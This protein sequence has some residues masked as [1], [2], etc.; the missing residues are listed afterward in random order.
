MVR[1][2]D[3]LVAR[4]A[5]AGI[6]LALACA[7]SSVPA[8]AQGPDPAPTQSGP[9]PDPAPGAQPAPTAAPTAPPVT[10]TPAPVVTQAPA[11]V[12]PAPTATA[13]EPVAT[14]RPAA[15]KHPRPRAHRRPHKVARRH[16][17][18]QPAGPAPQIRRIL[19]ESSRTPG[20]LPKRLFR[21]VA[22]APREQPQPQSQSRDRLL[23]GSALA[24]LAVAASTL[25][26][27]AQANRIRRELRPS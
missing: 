13:P 27:L 6:V 9:Q 14:P 21:P 17:E 22:R 10:Q 2:R 19:A 3:G 8:L 4:T 26:L 1:S 24:M 25:F 16:R 23:V 5:K 7:L 20:R 11:R 18:P 15:R 12:A